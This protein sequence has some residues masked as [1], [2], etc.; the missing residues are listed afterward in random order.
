[1]I[2]RTKIVS[3][4]N[5]A[6]ETKITGHPKQMYLNLTYHKCLFTKITLDS[7]FNITK[8]LNPSSMMA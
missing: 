2:I 6:A 3:K 1:V 7:K 4:P 5:L 8:M